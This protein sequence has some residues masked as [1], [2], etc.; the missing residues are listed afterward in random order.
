MNSNYIIKSKNHTT[1]LC[2]YMKKELNSTFIVKKRWCRLTP[3]YLILVIIPLFCGG[4]RE[5]NASFDPKK[6]SS[7]YYIIV[8]I[9]IFGSGIS[10]GLLFQLWVLVVRS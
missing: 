1:C 5:R 7:V 4:E 9:S 3:V 8:K 6:K 10:F 2:I